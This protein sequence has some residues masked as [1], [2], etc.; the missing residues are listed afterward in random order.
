MRATIVDLRYKMNQVL[1]ALERNETVSVLYRGKIK[2]VLSPATSTS[3]AK[4]KEHCFFG[5]R[6]DTQSVQE[7][8]GHGPAWAYVSCFCW[9]CSR[10]APGRPAVQQESNRLSVSETCNLNL[11][12]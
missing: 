10:R 6:K 11:S 1:K 5:C 2:G 9:W 7:V 8:M 4:V 3:T 12:E